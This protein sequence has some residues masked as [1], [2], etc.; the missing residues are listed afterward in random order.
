MSTR[1]CCGVRESQRHGVVPTAYIL[2][3]HEG[4][5]GIIEGRVGVVPGNDLG[6]LAHGVSQPSM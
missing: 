4:I 3:L 6:I 5:P 1:A 2:P